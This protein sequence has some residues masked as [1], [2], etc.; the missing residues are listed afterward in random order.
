MKITTKLTFYIILIIVFIFL[1][2][3]C[4]NSTNS[5]SEDSETSPKKDEVVNLDYSIVDE[6]G[7][8]YFVF[9][10]PEQYYSSPTEDELDISIMVPTAKFDSVE[11]LISSVKKGTLSD[12]QKRAIALFE[13]DE[14][15]RIEICN[16]DEMYQAKLPISCTV[17][18]VS[19]YGDHYTFTLDIPN[20]TAG[21][22]KIVTKD[23]HELSLKNEIDTVFNNPMVTVIN[24]ETDAEG[25]EI[26]YYST[27]AGYF[28]LIRYTHSD[29]T[30]DLTIIE[31][32]RIKIDNSSDNILY[33]T[34][35]VSESI[36]SKIAIYG[37]QSGQYFEVSAFELSNEIESDWILSFGISK[38]VEVEAS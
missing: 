8:N 35:T 5:Y 23:N 17:E 33:E 32:Y 37:L 34:L 28:K 16:L 7:K 24:T 12:E 29:E 3:G 21:Y 15:G 38:Y 10:N 31:K 11:E 6:K 9:D 20:A 2:S 14:N 26:T 13:K 36:P 4:S 30:R 18:N 22:L 27:S 1:V 19:W 25:R